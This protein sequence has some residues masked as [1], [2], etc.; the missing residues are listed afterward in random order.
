[1]TVDELIKKLKELPGDL[2]VIL[3]TDS[4][5]NGYYWGRGAE[6][7]IPEDPDE[8]RVET[9]HSL[10]YTAKDV[11]MEEDEWQKMKDTAERVVV[12]YP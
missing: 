12:I 11:D 4:A 5:G 2:R 7:G 9:V 8:W 10:N 6:V 1:M 3:Q